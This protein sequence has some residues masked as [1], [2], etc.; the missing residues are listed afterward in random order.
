MR[1]EVWGTRG[2]LPAHGSAT[3]RYGGNTSSVLVV[4]S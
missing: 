4:G 1:V 3:T 2:S